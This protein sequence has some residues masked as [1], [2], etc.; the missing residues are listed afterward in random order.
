MMDQRPCL[1]GV[2]WG[3]SSFRLWLFGRDGMVLAERRSAEG[4]S[5]LKP[6]QFEAV[7]YGHLSGAGGEGLPVILCGMVGAKQGW[8]EA[9]YVDV[10]ADLRAITAGTILVDGAGRDARI[11][12]GLAQR[13]LAHPDVM[14][15]EETQLLGLLLDQPDFSGTVVMPGTHSKWVR[16]ANGRVSGFA[17]HLTG[18]LYAVLS[19]HSIL[20]QSVGA[21]GATGVTDGFLRGLEITRSDPSAALSRLFTIRTRGLLFPDQ[22]ADA[23][24]RLSG[25][26]I[27]AEIAIAGATVKAVTLVADGRM[28]ML[29]TA[30]LSAAGIESKVA[31]A[32]GLVRHGLWHAGTTIW[33]HLMGASA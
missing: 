10:P 14:R 25:M 2:D 18:E 24:D 9:G 33:P 16:L 20:R 5:T 6:D 28:A 8:R 29:Y 30:A 21:A 12:P 3:T 13:Q 22:G 17:T 11:L 26:L 23:A 15:G 31:G 1:A 4:M 19:Q 7:L 32:D 27:G